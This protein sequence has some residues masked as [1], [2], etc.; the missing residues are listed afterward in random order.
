MGGG[1]PYRSRNDS[2]TP[3]SPRPTPAW[4]TAHRAG[5]PEHTAQPAGSWT[6]QMVSSPGSS[7]GLCFFQ[8]ASLVWVS[9]SSLARYVFQ[10]RRSLV[11]L[12]SSG[13]FLKPLNCFFPE[14]NELLFRMESANSPQNIQLLHLLFSTL[15]F[16]SQRQA[17]FWVRGQPGLQSEFQDIQGYTEKPCLE[18]PKNKQTKN[19]QKRFKSWFTI[20]HLG[21]AI[22][23][24][25]PQA[26][27]ASSIRDGGILCGSLVLTPIQMAGMILNKESKGK[28]CVALGW[29][30]TVT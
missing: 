13:K 21:F 19:K 17:D 28:L 2:K 11:N 22:F 16:M 18:K 1:V 6:G 26:Q 27:N 15:C 7:A 12:L 5:N 9:L 14:F 29:S 30:F 4:V 10:R 25:R 20:Y 24:T 23:G 3:A 8:S